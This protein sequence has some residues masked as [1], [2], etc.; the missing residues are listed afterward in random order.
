M[1]GAIH[2][3]QEDASAQPAGPPR[4]RR[5][6]ASARARMMRFALT[7]A[8]HAEVLAAASRAG[9]ARA[10][11]AAEATLAAA[12]GTMLTPDT[13]RDA[14]LGDSDRLDYAAEQLRKAGVNLNQA[15]KVLHQ[16]RQ[17]PGNL[18]QLAEQVMHWAAQVDACSYDLWSRA[19][20]PGPAGSRRPGPGSQPQIPHQPRRRTARGQPCAPQPEPRQPAR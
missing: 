3:D 2:G 17:P 4:R 5:R 10:A 12:R 8:E 6:E 16:T 14:S 11:F 7:E 9:Q 1:P 18:P 13:A 15:V 19:V 20:S